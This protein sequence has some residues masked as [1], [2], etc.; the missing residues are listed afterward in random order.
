[1]VKINMNHTQNDLDVVPQL[2]Y[3]SKALWQQEG[4]YSKAV[5]LND[6]LMML[7]C[8]GFSSGLSLNTASNCKNLFWCIY[9]NDWGVLSIPSVPS[10]LQ[11][12]LL[13]L[14]SSPFLSW[15]CC[16]NLTFCS[17]IK[18]FLPG[19][20]RHPPTATPTPPPSPPTPHP[21]SPLSHW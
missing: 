12:S 8:C 15:C 4:F 5:K 16:T 7:E 13:L 17:N 9:R 2:A 1:M 21:P 14:S 18:G 19:L 3:L 20:L 6:I 11:E 10:S